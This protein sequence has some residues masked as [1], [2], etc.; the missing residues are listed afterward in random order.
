M[1][2]C[3]ALRVTWAEGRDKEESK[4]TTPISCNSAARC[5]SKYDLS[6]VGGAALVDEEAGGRVVL[7]MVS[8]EG[9]GNEGT[10]VA[11]AHAL[12]EGW[13]TRTRVPY[14]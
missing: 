8:V 5:C 6:V 14:Y 12:E 7:D 10:V 11:E 9:G 13:K 2:R 1:F 4:H 3:V